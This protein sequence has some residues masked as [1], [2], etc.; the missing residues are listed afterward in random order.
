MWG[1]I[2]NLVYITNMVIFLIEA[3]F[4]A[5]KPATNSMIGTAT[6]VILMTIVFVAKSIK[7]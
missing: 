6:V 7:G 1:I 3:I 4:N 5:K 2:F